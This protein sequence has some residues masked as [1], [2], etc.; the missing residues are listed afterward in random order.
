[1]LAQMIEEGK[2]Q[3]WKVVSHKL[4]LSEAPEGYAKFDA[5]EFNKVRMLNVVSL[6]CWQLLADLR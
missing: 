5:K 4:P 2:L 1:V 3:P 6:G